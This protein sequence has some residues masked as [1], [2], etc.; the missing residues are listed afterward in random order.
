MRGRSGTIV[1][2]AFRGATAGLG[3]AAA[4]GLLMPAARRVGLV[5]KL[6]PE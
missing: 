6:A 2:P 5:D 3:A 1:G 4:M